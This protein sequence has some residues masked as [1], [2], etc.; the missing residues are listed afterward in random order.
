MQGVESDNTLDA[1]EELFRF[2]VADGF[3]R[4]H[5]MA[6]SIGVRIV[7]GAIPRLE[8]ILIGNGPKQ[9]GK[10]P[11]KVASITLLSPDCDLEPFRADRGHRLRG[12]SPLVTIYGD[13][14]DWALSIAEVANWLIDR[15]LLGRKPGTM[16]TVNSLDDLVSDSDQS[17]CCRAT[18]S[19]SSMEKIGAKIEKVG[20][21]DLYTNLDLYMHL[22]RV[23]IIIDLDY[24]VVTEEICVD[25]TNLQE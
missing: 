21:S 5:I 18:H 17:D 8:K 7:I 19:V 3:T 20:L 10:L 16:H 11:L 12:L 23:S 6:H 13:R 2:L 9:S 24:V 25:L 14:T 4:V 22:D 15:I 1:F